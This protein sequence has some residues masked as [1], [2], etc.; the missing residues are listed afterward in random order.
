ME[1]TILAEIKSWVPVCSFIM[2]VLVMAFQFYS[3]FKIVGNDLHHL[4]LDTKE[5]KEGQKE[6]IKVIGEM[7]K[8]IAYL[9]GKTETNDAIVKVLEKT[10]IK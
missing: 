8:D 2:T 1:T 5:L 7:G 6:N 4:A 9:K 3:H 10:I